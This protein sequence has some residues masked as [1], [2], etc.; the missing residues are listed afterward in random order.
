M[1]TFSQNFKITSP[2]GPNRGLTGS[3]QAINE[4]SA[5]QHF[6]VGTKVK[7]YD[8]VLGEAEF[9]YA[10]GVAST[11]AY[12]VI[13]LNADGTTTRAA[14]GTIKGRVGIAMSAN[15]A[16]QWGWYAICGAVLCLIAGDVTGDVVAYA[17]AT[18]GTL[19]DDV[20][21][22]SQ[23]AGTQLLNGLDA[24]GSAIPGTSDTTAAHTTVVHLSYP[25]VIKAV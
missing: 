5:T 16:N 4:T 24:G 22:G 6:V 10:K 15:V 12:E 21:A 7:A 19:A 11:A 17:T 25:Q 13:Q 18:A 14:G 20:V 9:I 3:N 1:A 23:I 8:P 2:I